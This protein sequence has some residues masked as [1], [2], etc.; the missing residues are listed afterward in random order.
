MTQGR[1]WGLLAGVFLFLVVIT[2]IAAQQQ[3][4][5]N[6][7]DL[8]EGSTYANG[9]GGT[10]ALYLWL[11]E[12]NFSVERYQESD[13]DFNGVD[14]VMWVLE[15]QDVTREEAEALAQWVDDG[16]TLV[17]V[18]SDSGFTITDAF[19]L[20]ETAYSDMSLY[21]TVPWFGSE[22]DS[23]SFTRYELPDGALP[24]MA[25]SD[26]NVGAMLMPYGEGHVW[27]FTDPSPFH[28]FDLRDP[29]ASTFVEGLLA[30]LPSSATHYFDEVHHGFGNNASL[31]LDRGL[32][33]T[34]VRTPW[35]WGILYALFIGGLWIVL[36]GRRF[37]R[38]IPLPNEHL[39]R[40]AGEYVQGM[41][42]L[43]RRSHLRAPIL[44]HYASRLKRRVTERYR[45]PPTQDDSTFLNALSR[46]RPDLNIQALG[47]HLRDLNTPNPSERK[48]QSLA[49]AN[50]G[51]MERLVRR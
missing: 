39:R 1:D 31:N 30:Q 34:M 10:R 48:M 15:P 44:R 46:V 28:N 33:Y 7:D 32:L 47:Q 16:G 12:M 37:G 9:R 49:E 2:L 29:A 13:Y 5:A 22:I 17:W 25:D 40:E 50:Q 14:G 18:P 45:L 41:A 20:E 11:D 27:I 38:P 23:G 51:W 26:G 36:R 35:G 6:T 4:Q 43:Y 3:A 21:P 19:A 42:W 24:L 8:I